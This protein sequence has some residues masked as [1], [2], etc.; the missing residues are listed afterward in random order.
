MRVAMMMAGLAAALTPAMVQAA[1][2]CRDALSPAGQMI[3]DASAPDIA[4][5]GDLKTVVSDKTEGL[6]MAG[7][8][9][10]PNARPAAEAAADCL[11]QQS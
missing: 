8:I 1:P 5:G 10:I 7:K 4:K 6:V 2:A 11:K 3:Y 9:D